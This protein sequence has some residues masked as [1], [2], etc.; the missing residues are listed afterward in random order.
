MQNEIEQAVLRAIETMRERLGDELTIDDLA[1]AALFSKFHFSRVFQRVTGLSPGRFLS[2]IRLQEAK[3]LLA[4]T[5]LPVTEISVQ[6][7]YS[8]VGTFSSRFK[9][10]VGVSP[11]SYRNLGR[12]TP[13]TAAAPRTGPAPDRTATV[14]GTIWSPAPGRPV[15]AGLFQG[16]IQQGEPVRCTVLREPGPFVLEDV[17]LGSW[18][19]LAQSADPDQPPG[20]GDG[21]AIGHVGP[22]T[23]R[24][25]TGARTADL[26]LRPM[27]RFDPPVLLALHDLR[28]LPQ[29][30]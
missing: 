28:S 22:I 21:M 24:P 30:A 20:S 11:T 4:T 17:P 1:Q 16:P 3:H 27:R 29:C 18:H 5:P 14:R 6:V 15:F 10:S 19:L 25:D 13:H 12:V 2:A 8:S 23:I 7:G 26:R 9:G